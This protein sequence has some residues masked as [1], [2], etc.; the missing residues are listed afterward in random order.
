MTASYLQCMV[1][2]KYHSKLAGDLKK[3]QMKEDELRILTNFYAKVDTEIASMKAAAA[4]LPH[5]AEKLSR[6]AN[7]VTNSQNCL[8]VLGARADPDNELARLEQSLGADSFNQ[9]VQKLD[10]SSAS[11]AAASEAVAQLKSLLRQTMDS[12]ATCGALLA[13][14]ETESVIG[15]SLKMSLEPRVVPDL[16]LEIPPP[17]AP[18]KLV[19]I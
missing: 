12:Y 4:V 13:A 3:R 19:D 18:P 7:A 9:L 6:L 2:F 15:K 8:K 10:G 5:C 16:N 17:V 1:T 14:L 11:V